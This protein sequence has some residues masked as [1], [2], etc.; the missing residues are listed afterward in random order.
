MLA[1]CQNMLWTLNHHIDEPSHRTDRML[2]IRE[3]QIAALG[4]TA[5][6]KQSTLDPKFPSRTPWNLKDVSL[7][8]SFPSSAAFAE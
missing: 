5:C 3:V 6:M 4:H 1:F 2:W 8:P 7:I